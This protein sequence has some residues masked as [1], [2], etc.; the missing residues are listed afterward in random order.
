MEEL[1]TLPGS[2]R[3]GRVQKKDILDYVK[4]R[5]APAAATTAAESPVVSKPAVAPAKAGGSIFKK[6]W[7]WAIVG[8]VVL[9]GVGAAVYFFVIA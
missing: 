5:T 2:G 7:L 4:T 6:W 1:D 9:G 3:D 8:V